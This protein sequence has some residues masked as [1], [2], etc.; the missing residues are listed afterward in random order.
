[1]AQEK[2][3][4]RFNEDVQSNKGYRYTHTNKLSCHLANQRLS[5]IVAEMTSLQNK[6]I[7]DIGCG[8]GTYTIGLLNSN[9]SF[10]LGVDAAEAA[11]ESARKKSEG[12]DEISFQVANVYDLKALGKKYDVAIVRGVLHHLYNAKEAIANIAQIAKEAVIVEPNGYNPVLKI[13]EKTSMYH[14]E[15]EEKSYSPHRLNGWI[16]QCGGVVEKSTYGGLVPMFCPDS[17][18]RF[19]KKVEPLVEA[20]P[21]FRCMSCAVYVIRATFDRA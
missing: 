15:H 21:L 6:R 18:A 5:S 13:I 4:S 2:N 8:D 9:P 19:L 16:R 14:I 17:M 12:L 10:I 11:I 7:I 1:M 3:I 20:I